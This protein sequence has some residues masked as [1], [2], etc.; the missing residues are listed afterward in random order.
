MAF[1]V[2]Y[3]V[4]DHTSDPLTER[5]KHLTASIN[6][7]EALICTL[8]VEGKGLALKK[9]TEER[10]WEGIVAKKK[11]S[12]YSFDVR[13]TEWMKIK[14]WRFID[15]VI[16]GY[17]TDPFALIV[18]LH[19]PTHSHQAILHSPRHP[20]NHDGEH[21]CLARCGPEIALVPGDYRWFRFM[22][23]QVLSRLFRIQKRGLLANR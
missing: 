15:T 11:D 20:P 13:S 16:L 7:I 2:L 6:P 17:K 3:T 10:G 18:G 22:S 5:K 19:F 23:P 12:R 8:G 21:P 14:N 4:R 1:D 9:M